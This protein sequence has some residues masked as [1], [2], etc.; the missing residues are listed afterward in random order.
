MSHHM[1][2]AFPVVDFLKDKLFCEWAYFIDFEKQTL[3]TWTDNAMIA[4]VSFEALGKD[5]LYMVNSEK[6][7]RK[8]KYGYEEEN[9]E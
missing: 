6:K 1:S 3:E 9:E 4:E 2:T 7:V 5:N 8:E